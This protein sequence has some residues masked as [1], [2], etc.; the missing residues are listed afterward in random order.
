MEK[1]L[2][3]VLER[4]FKSKQDLYDLLSIDCKFRFS[5]HA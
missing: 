1:V 2:P 5:K 3:E 4:K